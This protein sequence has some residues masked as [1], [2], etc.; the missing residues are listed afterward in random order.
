LSRAGFIEGMATKGHLDPLAESDAMDFPI[1]EIF[2]RL[3]GSKAL[4]NSLP[5]EVRDQVVKAISEL[6]KLIVT[7][8]LTKRKP[9]LFIGRTYILLNWLLN[10]NAFTGD[11]IS[12]REIAKAL[13]VTPPSLSPLS[14]ALSRRFGIVNRF[15]SHNWRTHLNIAPKFAPLTREPEQGGEDETS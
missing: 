1:D 4:L 11:G 9:D 7:D 15:Q 10:P 5:D 13:G 6:N 12:L 14:A 8:A 3:D 2:D